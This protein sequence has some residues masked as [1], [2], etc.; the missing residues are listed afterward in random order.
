M[1]LCFLGGVKGLEFRG[2]GLR[3]GLGLRFRV[4]GRR[5]LR[6]SILGSIMRF[7]WL[8]D[9]KLTL[10]VFGRLNP[11]EKGGTAP[12]SNRNRNRLRSSEA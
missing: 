9:R 5:A 12:E 2:F 11:Q 6:L 7:V 10:D 4:W 1:L 3:L 8:K